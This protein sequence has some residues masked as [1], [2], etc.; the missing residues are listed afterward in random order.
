[1]KSYLESTALIGHPDDLRE[2]AGR[3]GYLF[4]ENLLPHDAVFRVRA[5]FARILHN[6]GW[7]DPD[8]NPVDALT[9][10]PARLEGDDAYWPVLDDFQSLESFHSLPHHPRILEALDQLFGEQTLPHARNIGRIIFPNAVPYSTPPHQ[11]YVHIQGTPNT[12]TC[13]IPLGDAPQELGGGL[14]VAAGSHRRGLYPVQPALGAGHV[15]IDESLIIDEWRQGPM[16]CGS[17]L[18]FHSHTVHKAMPNLTPNRIRLSVDYRYQP[19]SGPITRNSMEPHFARTPWDKIYAGWKSTQY[20]YYWRDLP[21][22]YVDFDW[23][24]YRMEESKAASAAR[25][26]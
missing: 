4:F 7:L 21:L 5:D 18:L 16:T 9:T 24:V 3:D 26:Y 22:R 11:D 12:W 25:G 20:Q 15:G 6:H 19:L 23:S 10:Q 1:M 17:I 2:R 14:A 13:W 8:T